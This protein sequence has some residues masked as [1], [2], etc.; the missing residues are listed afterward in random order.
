[1]NH[2]N[3][4][5]FIRNYR[6]EDYK[7]YFRMPDENFKY[8]LAKVKPFIVKQDT[9]IRNAIT[10]EARIAATLGFLAPGRSF[11]DLKFATIISPQ[12]LG[13]NHS[14]DLQGYIQGS[15]RRIWRVDTLVWL[16]TAHTRTNQ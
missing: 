10:P 3:L 9:V 16:G 8:L 14:R 12:A 11:E 6:P 2:L 7:N 13:K 4:L 15:K 5:N 1:L